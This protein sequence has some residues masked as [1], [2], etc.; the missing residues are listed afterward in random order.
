LWYYWLLLISGSALLIISCLFLSRM[1]HRRPKVDKK[2]EGKDY[3][4]RIE[5]QY[6]PDYPGSLPNDGMSVR[7]S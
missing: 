5:S 1:W 7:I 4:D 3:K 2:K 6:C